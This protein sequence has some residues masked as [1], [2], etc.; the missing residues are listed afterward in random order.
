MDGGAIFADSSNVTTYCPRLCNDCAPESVA[1]TQ[2]D[3][4]SSST[5]TKSNYVAIV[6][7]VLCTLAVSTSSSSSSKEM[8][9][10]WMVGDSCWALAEQL[11]RAGLFGRSSY[12]I[13]FHIFFGWV[14]IEAPERAY[15]II[16]DQRFGICTIE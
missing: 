7:A 11:V 4:S 9:G 8:N 13:T 3:S 5:N 15:I 12:P 14:V 10:G 1:G 2:P 6:V 16:A